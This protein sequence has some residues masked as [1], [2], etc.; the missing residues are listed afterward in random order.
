MLLHELGHS[1]NSQRKDRLPEI[2]DLDY[3]NQ[4]DKPEV[5]RAN[6]EL[7]LWR[8]FTGVRDL[9]RVIPW[10]R[11]RLGKDADFKTLLQRLNGNKPFA[12]E[13]LPKQPAV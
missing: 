11:R 4:E 7:S 13:R 2:G 1:I 12:T 10:A 3:L 6:D 9:E 8:G 5:A